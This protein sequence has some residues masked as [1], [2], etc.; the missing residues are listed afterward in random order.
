MEPVVGIFV[1]RKDAA[2]ASLRLRS[3]GFAPEHVQLLLPSTPHAEDVMPT[4]DAEQSG[5]GQAVGG[6]VGG[7]MGASAG[8][9]LGAAVASLLV[10]GVGAVTAVGLAAAALLGAGGAV[11]GAALGGALEDK[12][13]EGLPRDEAYLYEDAL[14]HGRSIVFAIPES[15]DEEHKARVIMEAA[16]AESLDAAREEWWIGLRDDE[17]AHY[18]AAGGEFASAET[19]YRHGFT[20]ALHPENRGQAHDRVAR[21]LRKRHGEVADSEDFRRG[22]ARGLSH[23]ERFPSAANASSAEP[24]PAT[25][26]T[27]SAAVKPKRRGARRRT[28]GEASR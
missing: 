8:L 15:D 18:E 10:P 9:G 2:E 12:T 17:Q 7:A 11:G 23:A 25:D 24:P 4:E 13:R 21:A 5:V 20:S 1:S 26:S 22:Y 19:A 16:G 14:R 28:P 6:V 3:G 27:D